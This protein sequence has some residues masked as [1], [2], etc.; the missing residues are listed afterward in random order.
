MC[1]LRFPLDEML[2]MTIRGERGGKEAEPFKT[3]S[4]KI[5]NDS[6]VT[7]WLCISTAEVLLYTSIF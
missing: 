7:I 1:A 4:I 5:S 2:E 3:R 6:T